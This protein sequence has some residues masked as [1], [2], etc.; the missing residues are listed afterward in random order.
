ME[1]VEIEHMS[2]VISVINNNKIELKE[3]LEKI[4]IINS[5]K[6]AEKEDSEYDELPAMISQYDLS[7]NS[8]KRKRKRIQSTFSVHHGVEGNFQ[9]AARYNRKDKSRGWKTAELSRRAIWPQGRRTAKSS[10]RAV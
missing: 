1:N 4:N 10:R 9:D 3:L 2:D 5:S 6:V 8:K 7:S